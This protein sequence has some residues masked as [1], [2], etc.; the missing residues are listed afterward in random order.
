VLRREHAA[1]NATGV[2]NYDEAWQVYTWLNRDLSAVLP[3]QATAN[4]RSL[5]EVRCQIGQPVRIKWSDQEVA[6]ALRM[7]LGARSITASA[8]DPGR[9]LDKIE[10]IL[11]YWAQ[12][13]AQPAVA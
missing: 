6:G 3:S 10:V 1:P 4:E 8:A 12:L 13:T 5:A 9:V 2:L 7:A 11:R